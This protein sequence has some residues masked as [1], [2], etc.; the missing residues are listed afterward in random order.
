MIQMFNGYNSD[1]DYKEMINK[2]MLNTFQFSFEKWHQLNV[3]DDSYECY[4]IIRNKEII[5]NVSVTKM[6]LI[7]DSKKIEALQMGAV[8]TK[9][10]YRNQG[11][12]KQIINHI[13]ERY[14]DTP[15]FLFANDEVLEFYP[16]FGFEMLY[17]KQPYIEF[18][19][20]SSTKKLSSLKISD[21]K[22]DSYIK[23][24]YG[25]SN[26]FDCTNAYTINWFHLVM[27]LENDIYEIPELDTMIIAR[28]RGDILKIYDVVSKRNISFEDISKYLDFKDI[29]YI[30]FGFTP[31]WLNAPYN[32][33]DHKSS[34]YLHS[35]NLF[36]KGKLGISEN[37]K[38][39]ELIKT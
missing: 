23:G 36:I 19:S 25:Y 13:F 31:D 16:K 38:V 3:W 7:V 12:S 4:S 39:P 9:K 20:S 29:R 34:S 5:A 27:Q 37:F 6:E 30:E 2:L 32:I 8:A 33:K 35:S 26:I 18:Q 14:P 11:L 21:A 28:K 17:E 1:N 24:R 10:E 22:I 15:I